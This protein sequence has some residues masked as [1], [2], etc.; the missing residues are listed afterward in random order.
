MKVTYK[1]IIGGLMI[2]GMMLSSISV[3]AQ[4]K[5]EIR[6]VR[7]EKRMEGKR[8][9]RQ[10]MMAEKLNLSEEQKAKIEKIRL[11]H[12]KKNLQ[13]KNKL[14]EKRARFQTLKSEDNFNQKDID[15]VIDEMAEMKAKMMKSQVAHHREIRS[16]LT[17][18]QQLIFDV[19]KKH[20]KPMKRAGK[21]RKN[22][23]REGRR[24]EF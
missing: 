18:E 17:E 20:R 9:D 8:M 14:N 19:Q 12:Q 22:G 10:H 1:H 11:K 16:L 6:K 23:Q 21:G 3:H 5:R 15:K 4:Q 24:A 2:A 13:L 7:V